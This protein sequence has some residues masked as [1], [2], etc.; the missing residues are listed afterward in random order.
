M[1]NER[2]RPKYYGLDAI[3]RSFAHFILGK[4]LSAAASLTVLVI[5][6]RQLSIAEFAV[7]TSI[8]ALILVIGSLSSFGVNPV[9]LRY[10]PELRA[11]HNN[12]AMYRL[13]AWGLALRAALYA[14]A[15]LILLVFSEPLGALLKLGEWLWLL[16]AY[17]LVGFLR[18]NA[19]FAVEVLESLLWQREAQYSVAVATLLK[20][21]AVLI[22]VAYGDF[23]LEYFILIEGSAELL[24]LLLLLG[25]AFVRWLYDRE[26]TAG[27]A[28]VLTRDANRYLNYGLW[29]YAQHLSSIFHGSA[30]NR[31][32]ISYFLPVASIALFGVIDRFITFVRHYEPLKIFIGM[33]RPIFNSRFTRPGDFPNLVSLANL[34]F[35]VN[36]VVLIVPLILFAVAGGP[37]FD[38]I[39]AGNYAE[40]APIFLAF[41]AVVVIASANTLLD[42]LV[43]LVERTKIYT[44]SNLALSA[45]IFLAIPLMPLMGLWAL[46]LANGLGFVLSFTII[47]IYMKRVGYE[48]KFDWAL[49]VRAVAFALAAIAVGHLL[50][51]FGV[52]VVLSVAA[53]YAGFLLALCCWPPLRREERAL[54]ERVLLPGRRSQ[55]SKVSSGSDY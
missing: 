33:V 24:T 51:Q 26:R 4:G 46:A 2:K 55:L 12:R 54:V 11:A 45:S 10:L 30:P 32:F 27:D 1:T 9:L 19:T 16:P 7:Y 49:I 25:S 13:L 47:M 22:L 21:A 43:K 52:S 34:L 3:R 23:S 39:T 14:M 50:L 38:W 48:V 8:N 53:A 37:L 35:R 6:T 29:T 41:Y 28:S 36:L 15:A 40:A 18:V 17:A 31:L 42:I 20:L 5:L 44:L